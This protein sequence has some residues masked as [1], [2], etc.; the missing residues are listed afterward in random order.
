[1]F[2][3]IFSTESSTCVFKPN[4]PCSNNTTIN[5]NIITKLFLKKEKDI[6]KEINFN[7]KISRLENSNQ[8]SVVLYNKCFSPDYKTL[9]KHDK[10]INATLKLYKIYDVFDEI[11]HLNRED[12][13]FEY[14]DSKKSIFIDD[15]FVERFQ[16]HKEL[17]I[18][19][20]APDTI[21]SLLL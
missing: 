17:K 11:I 2:S 7:K 16:V 6:N 8:W 19:V 14:M 1:M 3:N 10:D 13:K 9:L 15:S 5:N 18:P 21:E 12:H 4:L 20:F